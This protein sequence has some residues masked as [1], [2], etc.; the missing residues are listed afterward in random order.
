MWSTKSPLLGQVRPHDERPAAVAGTRTADGDEHGVARH[1]QPQGAPHAHSLLDHVRAGIDLHDG[2]AELVAH[3]DAVCVDGH[4]IRPVPGGHGCSDG[5]RV[6]SDPVNRPVQAVRHPRRAVAE[7]DPGRAVPDVDRGEDL[8]PGRWVEANHLV[9]GTLARPQRA[10]AESELGR[11][12][13]KRRRR[14]ALRVDPRDRSVAGVR[15][16]DRAGRVDDPDRLGPDADRVDDRV[17]A[18]VDA[19]DRAVEAVD[20]PNRAGAGRNPARAVTN[21]NR[22]DDGVGSRVDS[23][24]RV[25][26][27]VGDP[28]RAFAERDCGGCCADAGVRDQAT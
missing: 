20:H 13:R 21:R 24:H 16:P 5:V 1:R 7:S 18:R 3:P 22:L 12:D 2:A 26:V 25:A 23:R 6:G 19:R 17:R 15:D 8:L 14:V 28:I 10:C 27:G 9:R 11:G 4:R